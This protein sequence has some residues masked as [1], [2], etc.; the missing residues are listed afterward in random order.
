MAEIKNFSR[1]KMP[2]RQFQIDDDIFD[3]VPEIPAGVMKLFSQMFKA[4]PA[5]QYEK[6]AEMLDLFLLP[7]SAQL[8]ADRM[9]S[10][11]NPITMDHINSVIEWLMEEF[12]GRP[13]QRA[14][15][16]TTSRSRTGTNSTDGAPAE[17]ALL[18]T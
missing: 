14:K 5:D 13:T 8:F 3:C 1:P 10:Q 2:D 18:S 4:K 11:T 12:S 7:D 17:D 16:S 9:V 6:L 15:P